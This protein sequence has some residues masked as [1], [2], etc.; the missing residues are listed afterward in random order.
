MGIIKGETMTHEERIQ[1]LEEYHTINA[2]AISRKAMKPCVFCDN[3]TLNREHIW[4]S[5]GERIP[6]CE[7]CLETDDYFMLREM[8]DNDISIRLIHEA[9][10]EKNRDLYRI[11]YDNYWEFNYHCPFNKIYVQSGKGRALIYEG[12]C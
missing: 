5:S 3:E 2:P 4:K 9:K 11:P 8:W 12:G 10:Y 6:L 1:M 7:A